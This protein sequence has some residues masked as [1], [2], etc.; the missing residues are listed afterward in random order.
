M[1]SRG[2]LTGEPAG[3]VD[4]GVSLGYAREDIARPAP[5]PF[6]KWVGGKRQLLPELL[7]YKPERFGTYHEPFVGG[8]ALFFA[9][10]PA[11][12]VL[13]DS[14]PRLVRTWRG[15]R[16]RVEEVIEHLERYDKRHSPSFFYEFRNHPIDGRSD[17]EVAAWFIYLNKT[18]YNGLYRVNS[19][20]EFNVPVGNYKNPCICDAENLRACSVAL[21]GVELRV[22]D[23]SAV[24]SRAREGDFVYF[25][26][27]YVPLSATSL[28]VGYTAEK[29]GVEQQLKL[30]NVARAL[31]RKGV[32]VVLSNSAAGLVRELYGKGFEVREVMASRAVNCR[33]SGR[34]KIQ[35]LIIY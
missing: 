16:D 18:A 26:P 13:S 29:F 21:T 15:I 11:N 7:M 23:F 3:Y 9:L 28:F 8:G 10:R 35:E 30:R 17:A 32:S 2:V 6:V 34:G 24:A 22:E 31:K 12:A 14:N 19:K 33:A 4:Y 5:R 20:N 27:P 25:D 1:D